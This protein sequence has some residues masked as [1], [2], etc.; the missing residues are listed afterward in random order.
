MNMIGHNG[1]PQINRTGWVAISRSMREHPLVGFHLHAK[2]MDANRGATQPALAFID[3]IMDCRYEPGSV[4]NGGHKML[5]KRGEL[6]GA[7]SFLASR[8]NW[9]PKAVRGWLDRLEADGMIARFQRLA[10]GV[11]IKTE[12][13]NRNGN[14][15]ALI[16]LCN[17]ELY[18]TFQSDEWQTQGQSKGNRGA[19][20][21]QSKGNNN[22]DNK[23]TKEQRNKE[24]DPQTPNG[25]SVPELEISPKLTVRTVALEAFREWQDFAREYNLAIP[26]DTTFET[27]ASDIIARMREHASEKTRTSMLDVWHLALCH[28][29][30]SKF[31]RGF[32]QSDF[33]A[34]LAMITRKKNFAKLISGGYDGG[35]TALSSRWRMGSPFDAPKSEIDD[36]DERREAIALERERARIKAESEAARRA[37]LGH[38]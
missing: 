11:E 16:K 3:L 19:I 36:E 30:R 22:K 21:G 14:Q 34:E 27:F 4:Y 28:V 17:Y 10:N 35:A 13:G 7:I 2:P 8:W 20:E 38:D 26:R 12:K 18:Q 23:E 32:G 6:I 15:A 1:P 24:E 37:R 25:G 31:L 33:K 9:T 29:A 5:V